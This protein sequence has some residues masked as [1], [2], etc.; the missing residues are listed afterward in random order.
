MSDFRKAYVPAAEKRLLRSWLK[1]IDRMAKHNPHIIIRSDI[2]TEHALEGVCC[3]GNGRPVSIVEVRN[4]ISEQIKYAE[5]QIFEL[6]EQLRIHENMLHEIDSTLVN[7][8]ECKG[9]QGT[10][11]GHEGP[12][13]DCKTCKGRGVVRIALCHE[14]QGIPYREVAVKRRAGHH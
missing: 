10:G 12:W 5:I 6:Q 3:N 8:P 14:K 11:G 13:K 7:C 9:E 1:Q 4:G 2:A